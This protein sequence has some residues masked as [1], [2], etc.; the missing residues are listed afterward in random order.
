[1]LLRRRTPPMIERPSIPPDD[2]HRRVARSPIR[3]RVWSKPACASLLERFRVAW[4]WANEDITGDAWG[5]SYAR[6][7]IL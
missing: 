2:L 1:M 5:G 7:A 6:S 4:S 3:K